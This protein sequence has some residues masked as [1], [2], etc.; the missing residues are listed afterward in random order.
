MTSTNIAA[1]TPDNSVGHMLTRSFEKFHK[2]LTTEALAQIP[3]HNDLNKMLVL[4]AVD[5]ATV[6]KMHILPLRDEIKQVPQSNTATTREDYLGAI[7]F[8]IAKLDSAYV[9]PIMQLSLEHI[10]KIH[11]YLEL[12][13]DLLDVAAGVEVKV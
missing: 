5:L 7:N 12:F 9:D 1:G 8:I 6:L 3:H 4:N 11:L 10:Q 2:F 13:I